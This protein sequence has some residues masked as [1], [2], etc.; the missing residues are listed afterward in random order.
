[1]G[2]GGAYRELKGER[3]RSRRIRMLPYGGDGERRRRRGGG[4]RDTMRGMPLCMASAR[5]G[6]AGMRRRGE[7]SDGGKPRRSGDKFRGGGENSALGKRW[8]REV[9]I[10]RSPVLKRFE[11]LF[12]FFWSCIQSRL[13]G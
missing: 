13:T 4:E 1:M 12:F 10:H 11:I 9:A 3:L 5:G 7:E 2:S 8:M 6:I